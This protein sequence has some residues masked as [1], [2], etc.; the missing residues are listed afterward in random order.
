VHLAE[1]RPLRRVA[2]PALDHQVVDLAR[3]VARL[4]EHHPL[5]HTGVGR[6]DAG[7]LVVAAGAVVDDLV[8]GER[9]ER[10]LA[11]E[12]QDLPQRHG[13]RP[14]VTLRRKLAL[15]HIGDSDVISLY[16]YVCRLFSRHDVGQVLINVCY[17]DNIFSHTTVL[18]SFFR[19]YPESLCQKKSS[20]GLYGARE[21]D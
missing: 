19:D 10:S 2:V 20:S 1:R 3:T 8:V 21:E 15:I 5:R 7:G 9:V 18:R 11:G 13:E 16:H 6:V 12:R 17:C 4:T 14:D